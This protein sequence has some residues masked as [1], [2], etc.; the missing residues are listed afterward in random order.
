MGLFG[1]GKLLQSHRDH[2]GFP[3]GTMRFGKPEIKK[4]FG[5]KYIPGIFCPPAASFIF[6]SDQ[7]G[8]LNQCVRFSPL[9]SFNIFV[10]HTFNMSTS[11][12][13]GCCC[14]EV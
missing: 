13:D 7:T 3:S 14:L 1:F 4:E 11:L 2:S 9:Y 6:R 10:F 5:C 12:S 8:N